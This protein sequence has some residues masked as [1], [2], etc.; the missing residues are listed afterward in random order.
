MS[1][2]VVTN[3][4]RLCVN[5]G[6]GVRTVVFLKGCSLQCPWC[7]NP[8][9]IHIN[10]ELVFDKGKCSHPE[11]KAYCAGC[12]RFGGMR[13][14]L[15]CPV[16]AFTTTHDEY[17]SDELLQI[18]L[19]D[20]STYNNGGGVTLSGGEPLLQIQ[21]LLPVL[22]ALK[23]KD[24]HIAVE[25]ALYVPTEY[26]TMAIPYVD[27]WLVDLKFQFGYFANEEVVVAKN[28]WEK[29][30]HDLQQRVS[31]GNLHYRMVLMHEAMINA[32]KMVRM[33]QQHDIKDIELL[34]CHSLAENKYHQLGMIPRKYTALTKDDL[35][36]V[37]V[38]LN[39]C[40][41][42]YTYIRL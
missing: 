24:I 21:V 36:R 11:K 18:L 33:I 17:S 19:R 26:V 20:E 3:I 34:E 23:E 15:E 5:D 38:L 41:I 9:T 30:L 25:T 35:E 28:A 40:N 14:K 42:N 4:Q 13:P 29:N 2:I 1:K 12:E 39:N 37:N 10:K 7:C 16:H 22:Q 31:S 27:Y 6:P 8:E 32:E